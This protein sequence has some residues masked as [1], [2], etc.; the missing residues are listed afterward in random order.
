MKRKRKRKRKIWRGRRETDLLHGTFA[1]LVFAEIVD[2]GELERGVTGD[3]GWSAGRRSCN[4]ER[5][6]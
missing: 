3:L 5:E 1:E 4:F 2:V 6:E